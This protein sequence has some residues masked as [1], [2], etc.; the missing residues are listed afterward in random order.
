M[1]RIFTHELSING[2]PTPWAIEALD[3][4]KARAVAQNDEILNGLIRDGRVAAESQARTDAETFTA[5]LEFLKAKAIA[6]TNNKFSLFSHQLKTDTEERKENA[7][8]AAAKSCAGFPDSSSVSKKATCSRQ[9]MD[10]LARPPSRSRSCSHSRS[11]A[12]SP[13]SLSTPWA[14]PVVE[15]P[16]IRTL[17]DPA[18][19]LLPPPTDASV[20]PP[21]NSFE[22]AMM[23][24]CTSQLSAYEPF[25]T[26]GTGASP[27]LNRSGL[28]GLHVL[29]GPCG[30][31][32]HRGRSR[33]SP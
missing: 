18:L 31:S 29:H 28:S 21:S 5:T 33:E 9:R 4:A 25:R 16:P 24:V 7:R 1:I 17:M 27:D 3:A 11:H 19:S 12:P 8:L 20:G 30:R 26:R 14:S 10:P 32:R 13:K 6:R 2:T 23:D 15:L 22:E